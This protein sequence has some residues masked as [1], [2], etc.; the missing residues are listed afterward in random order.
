M[1]PWWLT[2]ASG[3]YKTLLVAAFLG[4][5]LWETCRP[6]QVLALPTEKRWLLHG[7]FLILASV[8]TT[9]VFR[10]SAVVVAASVGNSPYGL[11]N[12]GSIPFAV[13]AVFSFLLLDLV[14]Y[15][16][17]YLR[18]SIPL[19]WRFHKVHHSDSEVD[20][21][22]GL[23]FHPGEIV[24]TQGAYLL[25]IAA[26]APPASVVLCFE[27]C[28]AVQ[29]FFSHANINLPPR[30]ERALRLIQ[31]TPGLH[32]IHHS[33]H[34]ADQRCN[35]A[36]MFSFWDR[37]FR[38]YRERS[39][40]GREPLAL[41]VDDVTAAE[42]VRPWAMLILPFWKGPTRAATALPAVQPRQ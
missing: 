2:H 22:T 6:R 3:V 28:N 4:A 9:L 18:H 37:L 27:V 12:R 13:R 29:A 39:N 16:D 33:R 10:A 1:E 20:F 30:L 38:T 23:R 26:A 24:F 5:A 11:L 21:S 8:T 31:V 14:Q 42:S 17:H 35:F 25:A 32:E 15:V 36:V 40:S 7:F 34:G 41:G 19:L